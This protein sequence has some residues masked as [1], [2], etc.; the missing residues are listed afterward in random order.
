M[1]K[2]LIIGAHGQ[3]ARVAARQLLERTGAELT[4]FLR[5]AQRL[6][7]MAGHPLVRIIEGDAADQ[8]ALAAA[9]QGQEVVYANLSGDMP[10]QAQ[11]IVGAM[12]QAGVR[13]LIFISS[14]GIYGEIPGEP[15][16]RILD[17]YRDSAAI[18]ESSG[19]DWTVIRPAWLTDVP[20]IAYGVTRKGEA[21]VNAGA[22][23][24]RASVADL[25]VR[26][27]TEPGFGIVE[28]FGVHHA[29]A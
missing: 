22:T 28:S 5:R 20:S 21:F 7:H 17:P 8:A 29:N 15:Y 19:L 13:R 14:M 10:R 16:R 2:V 1:P 24:S 9:M 26:I 23:V 4:L 11:A 6:E 3:I 18:V 27:V 12:E 25:I